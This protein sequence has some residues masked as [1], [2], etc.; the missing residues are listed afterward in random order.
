MKILKNLPERLLF[1]CHQHIALGP[2]LCQRNDLSF[3]QTLTWTVF[4]PPKLNI[5]PSVHPGTYSLA[6]LRIR[7]WR[8]KSKKSWWIVIY[9]ERWEFSGYSRYGPSV[10]NDVLTLVS[11]VHDMRVSG[12]HCG[13]W[14]RRTPCPRHLGLGTMCILVILLNRLNSDYCLALSSCSNRVVL[15]EW[16]MDKSNE[17]LNWNM[18]PLKEG[19]RK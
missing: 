2:H 17:M 9:K 5:S 10:R 14:G 12:R 19:P 11:K 8:W 18:N 15:N 1:M 4:Q 3:N 7:E 13:P 6:R 16:T